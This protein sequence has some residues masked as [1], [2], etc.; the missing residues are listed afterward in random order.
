MDD[1]RPRPAIRSPQMGRGAHRV[2]GTPMAATFDLAYRAVQN[3]VNAHPDSPAPVVMHITDG[4]STDGDPTPNAR[5]VME[6]RTNDGHALVFNCHITEKNVAQIEFPANDR[7]IS[8]L[9]NA[10]VMFRMS[11]P[12]PGPMA[13][14]A[15]DQEFEVQPGARGCVYQADSDTLIRF[16]N[17]GSVGLA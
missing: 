14:A 17:F 1:G 11:S 15:R 6:L 13:E 9:S 8:S 10:Q 16:I 12:L 3:W 4:E 7:E 2:G 5:K